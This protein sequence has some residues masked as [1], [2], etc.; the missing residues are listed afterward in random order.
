MECS[1]QKSA[2]R[3]I[4]DTSPRECDANMSMCCKNWNYLYLAHYALIIVKPCSNPIQLISV[5]FS[6]HFLKSS[7]CRGKSENEWRWSQKKKAD[8][9]VW[10]IRIISNKTA[11]SIHNVSRMIVCIFIITLIIIRL[12]EMTKL[13]KLCI[14]Y[15]G[16]TPVN[17]C[18][19]TKTWRQVC[20]SGTEIRKA[21]FVPFLCLFDSANSRAHS[22]LTLE[23]K[24]ANFSVS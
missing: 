8:I 1:V 15:D 7:H 13:S 23:N 4:L 10:I 19:F 9:V 18:S 24:I 14:E 6:F 5:W 16:N 22:T 3:I 2:S 17:C 20:S 11:L 12:S 21:K